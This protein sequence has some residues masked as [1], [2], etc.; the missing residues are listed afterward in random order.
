MLTKRI[1]YF[2]QPAVI[3]CDGRCDKAWGINGRPKKQLSKDED[4]YV[5]KGDEE[6][7]TAP[8]PGKTRVLSEGGDCKPSDVPL[9]D[10][11]EMNKWCVRECERCYLSPPGKSK[12]P[13]VLPDMK[14]PKP[15]IPRESK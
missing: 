3:A 11:E 7:G 14:N 10:P 12:E 15:N 13:I 1:T 6:L 4:D 8:K 9:I 5:F 2:G